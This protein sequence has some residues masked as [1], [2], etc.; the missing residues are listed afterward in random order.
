M[1]KW[2]SLWSR[3]KSAIFT[4]SNC[5]VPYI[6]CLF[7][8]L[9]WQ[10][11]SHYFEKLPA[12]FSKKASR[13]YYKIKINKNYLM[14]FVRINDLDLLVDFCCCDF[15][16]HF[17]DLLFVNFAWSCRIAVFARSASWA[18]RSLV[19]Y[20]RNLLIAIAIIIF[21]TL[22]FLFAYNRTLNIFLILCWNN[23]RLEIRHRQS[24]STVCWEWGI[25]L[26]N[27]LFKPANQLAPNITR[28][29][30]LGASIHWL[31]L[32][33]SVKSCLS[34]RSNSFRFTCSYHSDV[35]FPNL[36]LITLGLFI[37]FIWSEVSCGVGIQ[38]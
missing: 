21:S 30:F 19:N 38:P 35:T 25:R 36:L 32:V 9:Q 23:K 34:L 18:I 8:K 26:I 31:F 13:V 14:L 24:S 27:S 17:L 29:I 5:T 33:Q 28:V 15:L 16:L 11:T 10:H 3:S 4:L 7:L 1:L 22:L 2:Y 37:L 20:N 6:R 12:Q